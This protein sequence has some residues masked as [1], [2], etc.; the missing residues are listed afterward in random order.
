MNNKG[1]EPNNAA[2]GDGG[3][4]DDDAGDDDGGGDLGGASDDGCGDHGDGGGGDGDWHNPGDD[5]GGGVGA[6]DGA[7]Y[8][9]FHTASLEGILLI[10]LYLLFFISVFLEYQFPSISSNT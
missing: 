2:V 1:S 4:G 6:V 10:F 8:A 3:G 9:A 5:D 7:C